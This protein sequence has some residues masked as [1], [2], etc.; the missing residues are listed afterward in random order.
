ML[1]YAVTVIKSFASSTDGRPIGQMLFEFLW[2]GPVH[3]L[4]AE[5]APGPRN[6][7]C[8]PQEKKILSHISLELLLSA[9]GSQQQ[10][11]PPAVFSSCSERSPCRPRLVLRVLHAYF[12]ASPST[13]GEP[14]QPPPRPPPPRP[15]RQEGTAAAPCA[16]PSSAPA[17]RGSPSRG[18][19]SRSPTY[20]SLLL[21]TVG[22]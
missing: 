8:K 21:C 2:P 3:S 19:S 6:P 9:A 14:S 1:L 16:T 18:T 10:K 13:P 4:R 15:L 7:R 12:P 5:N 17:S 11:P 22:L 20:S